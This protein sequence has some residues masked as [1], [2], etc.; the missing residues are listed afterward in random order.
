M[1]EEVFLTI[2]QAKRQK[3]HRILESLKLEKTS[4]ITE[5]SL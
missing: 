4:N 1:Y 2:D 3:L 5:S